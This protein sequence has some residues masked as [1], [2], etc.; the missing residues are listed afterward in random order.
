MNGPIPRFDSLLETCK[1]N[2]IAITKFLNY[3]MQ[4][5]QRKH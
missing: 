5:Y 1:D 4:Q 2:L 3:K